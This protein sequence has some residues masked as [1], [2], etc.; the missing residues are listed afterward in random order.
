MVNIKND[1]FYQFTILE[2]Y[3][4]LEIYNI[5]GKSS[6]FGSIHAKS[7]STIQNQLLNNLE[8]FLSK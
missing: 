8:Y 7:S 2:I 5:N 3:N 1:G 4:R 6:V